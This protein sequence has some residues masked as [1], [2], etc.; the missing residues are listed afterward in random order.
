[1]GGGDM[2]NKPKKDRKP[3]E[4]DLKKMGLEITDAIQREQ[5]GKLTP[6][7]RR[8]LTRM[9]KDRNQS[10]PDFLKSMRHLIEAS[11]KPK[12]LL[13]EMPKIPTASDLKKKEQK[14]RADEMY[15]RDL[16]DWARRG[17]LNKKEIEKLSHAEANGGEGIPTLGR[18]V[19]EG[20]ATPRGQTFSQYL[21]SLLAINDFVMKTGEDDFDCELMTAEDIDGFA[22]LPNF[23]PDALGAGVSLCKGGKLALLT[24]IAKQENEMREQANSR[25]KWSR[26]TALDVAKVWITSFYTTVAHG[27]FVFSEK[28]KGTWPLVT[29]CLLHTH[30]AAGILIQNALIKSPE[31]RGLV[32]RACAW[33]REKRE[34]PLS[35]PPCD[36]AAGVYEGLELIKDA[37]KL[38]GC[39]P[40]EPVE[41]AALTTTPPEQRDDAEAQ[42]PESEPSASPAAQQPSAI[43]GK[44]VILE[45]NKCLKYDGEHFTIHG[46]ERWNDIR[47]LMDA[48]GEYVELEDGFP[49]RFAQGDARRFRMV[50]TEA[51]GVGRNGTKRY[52]IKP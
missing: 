33:L 49:Q 7:E 29:S 45:L 48:N 3:I 40:A 4:L 51:E 2:S 16:A 44:L 24:I 17:E 26:Q 52:K 35:N 32:A 43:V 50:A 34:N 36:A 39:P 10:L 21:R 11:A 9:A 8:K 31:Q 27:E 47:A 37:L 18:K 46:D 22:S 20:C 1:M 19:L 25:G 30:E 14:K 41:M 5:E 13:A 23:V 15:F 12:P 28:E 38:Q 6:A 42:A